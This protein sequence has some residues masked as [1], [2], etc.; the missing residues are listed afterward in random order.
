M[1]VDRDD[2]PVTPDLVLRAYWAG[3]FP[4]ADDRQGRFSWYRPRARAVITWDRFRIPRSLARFGRRGMVKVTF[5][6]DFEGVITACAQRTPTWICHDIQTLFT[7]LHQAGHAHSIEAWDG[8]G[9]LVGGT[10][11]LALGGCFTAES[12][13]HRLPNA[14]KWCL[15]RLVAHLQA[16]GFAFLDCQ[17]LSPAVGQLGAWTI[18]DSTYDAW[19]QR[20]EVAAGWKA[21]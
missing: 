13:F 18:D 11:G 6:L 4:M 2:H 15:V 7:L 3:C 20:H 8:E 19:L 5:D 1:I 12:M 17:Q 14:G 16:C 21:G 9:Q 10:Y